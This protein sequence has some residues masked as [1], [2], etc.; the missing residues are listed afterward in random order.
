VGSAK[1]WE[2]RSDYECIGDHPQHDELFAVVPL[3]LDL[4]DPPMILNPSSLL[5]LF[6]NL[7]LNFSLTSTSVLVVSMLS[8]L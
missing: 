8:G 5:L 3:P 4:H 1:R 7:S 6:S 2:T